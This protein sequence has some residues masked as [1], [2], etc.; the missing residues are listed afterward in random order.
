MKKKIFLLAAA[1]GLFMLLTGCVQAT[2]EST[3]EFT[4]L[5]GAGTKTIVFLIPQDGETVV[6]TGTNDE[7]ETTYEYT[8]YN[9]SSYFPQGYEAFAEWIIAQLPDNG[10]TYSID[11][12]DASNIKL[13]FSY[14][15]TSFEDYTAKTKALMGDERW[16]ASKFVE[17]QLYVSKVEDESDD[18][19]GKLKITYAE[20][21][22]MNS[23]CV[24]RILEIGFSVEAAEAGV[25]APYGD[26]FE[27]GDC[28]NMYRDNAADGESFREYADVQF[29]A[30][31][32]NVCD[33]KGDRTYILNGATYTEKLGEDGQVS[34]YVEDDGTWQV[35]DP[36]PDS[37]G[38]IANANS[39]QDPTIEVDGEEV[40]ALTRFAP[41]GIAT[42]VIIV[43]VAA[44][45]VV[46]AVIIIAVVVKK[47][48]DSYE[49]DDEDEDE[50]E[51]DEE[52]D[53]EE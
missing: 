30:Q 20:S 41:E 24:S 31:P 53:E 7:G 40:S 23:S 13:S 32:S 18:N 27:N 29:L 17:P 46:A 33:V 43:I 34:I 47:K 51:E 50:E 25:F 19:Y 11:K 26:C 12:S 49:D 45:V 14:S 36:I 8:I 9:N 44:V 35:T 6:E 28:K 3:L 37:L 52:E 15:F 4:D 2:T 21:R 42:W 16:E 48:N 22:Y 10:Y 38:T 39:P 1:L 5:N